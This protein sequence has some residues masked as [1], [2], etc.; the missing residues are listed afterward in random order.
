MTRVR[1]RR[2]RTRRSIT[3][4]SR[5]RRINRFNNQ[6]YLGGRSS[7][8]KNKKLR[9]SRKKNRKL[10]GGAPSFN[11][12]DSVEVVLV[13]KAAGQIMKYNNDGTY[14]VIFDSGKEK[15]NI[16]ESE[17]QL[18]RRWVGR[19][20][21]RHGI[22]CY[23]TNKDHLRQISHPGRWDHPDWYAGLVRDK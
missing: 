15:N 11:I 9:K 21:C 23:R 4:R 16:P 1:T 10:Y 17:I 5:M 3:R 7:R 13:K 12:G 14:K 2:S 22:D 18:V 20:L 8:Y 6:Y 19:P